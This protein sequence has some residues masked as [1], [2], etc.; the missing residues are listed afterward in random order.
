LR[1]D[2]L[3][4]NNEGEPAVDLLVEPERSCDGTRPQIAQSGRGKTI[5]R[6]RNVGF[7][8]KAVDTPKTTKHKLLAGCR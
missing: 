1:W 2:S 5:G 8:T 7:F 4:R 6:W 3:G